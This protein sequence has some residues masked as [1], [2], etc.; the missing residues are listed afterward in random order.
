MQI[1]PMGI[2]SFFRSLTARSNESE[3][4]SP[5]AAP[6]DL[7]KVSVELPTETAAELVLRAVNLRK[8]ELQAEQ[9]RLSAEYSNSIESAKEKIA[10]AERLVSESGVDRALLRI[11]E[12][13]WHWPTWS[14]RDD[15]RNYCNIEA[16]NLTAEAFK[17][18]EKEGIRVTF[19][20]HKSHLTF[21]FL[22]AK[23]YA[24]D[25]TKYGT[26]TLLEDERP[27]VVISI[28]HDPEKHRE[29]YQWSRLSTEQLSPGEW[30]LRVVE[31]QVEIEA[32]V[33]TQI[34]ELQRDRILTQAAN[35]PDVE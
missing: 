6:Q 15:F 9:S 19:D 22:E 24:P 35:L 18:E 21:V 12:E 17:S 14:K 11:L 27:V 3:S 29:Y 25:Y 26:V 31:M 32:T 1:K 30:M 7:A 20:Y 23:S 28:Y 34:R 13:F 2:F 5:I 33:N 8:D 4:T 16:E 10:A